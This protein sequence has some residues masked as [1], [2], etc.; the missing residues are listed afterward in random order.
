MRRRDVVLAWLWA[1]RARVV[2]GVAI[3]T[4]A[5]VTGVVSYSH[6]YE[7][8]LA[9]HQ[10][11]M[12]ARL[13]PF[14]VDGLMVVGS[15][16]LLQAGDK[17]G[18]VGIGAGT[19]ISLYAN[20]ESA[21]RYGLRAALWASVPALTF[22]LSTLIFERWVT[23][24]PGSRRVRED[25]V[26]VP[27]AGAVDAPDVPAVGVPLDVPDEVDVP[28]AAD[29]GVP[30]PDVSAVPDAPEVDVPSVD[31]PDEAPADV[32]DPV[33]GTPAATRAQG[34]QNRE[35]VLRLKRTTDWSQARIAEELGIDRKTVGRHLAAVNGSSR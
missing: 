13:M 9:M 31:V 33:G 5:V 27:V 28:G 19:A 8:S 2:A 34:Q 11:P 23:R 26:G 10:S 24:R 14:G 22:A 29:A 15:V 17:F 16:V 7:L 3:L 20:Y 12:V 21:A 18:W 6:I 35:A 4:V 25:A 1:R 30:P 32:P